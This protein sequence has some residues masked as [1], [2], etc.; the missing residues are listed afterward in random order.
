M[1]P[2]NII[3]EVFYVIIGIIFISSPEKHLIM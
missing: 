2:A 1:T 3:A